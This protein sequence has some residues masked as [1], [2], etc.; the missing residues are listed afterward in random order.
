MVTPNSA[1]ATP[2][3][4]MNERGAMTYG[5]RF[6]ELHPEWEDECCCP[7]WCVYR[8][9]DAAGVMECHSPATCGYFVPPVTQPAAMQDQ[10]R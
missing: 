9:K 10:R 8:H 4:A 2:C 6:R 3:G 5:E 7:S 1:S